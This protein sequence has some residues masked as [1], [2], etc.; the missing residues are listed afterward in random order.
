MFTISPAKV[1][2]VLMFVHIMT[3][4][5][6]LPQRRVYFLSFPQMHPVF[7]SYLG[8]NILNLF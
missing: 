6:M 3:Y 5:T 2:E 8:Y 4:V 1:Q 7:C